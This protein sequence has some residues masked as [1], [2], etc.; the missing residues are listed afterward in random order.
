MAGNNLKIPLIGVLIAIYLVCGAP[1]FLHSDNAYISLIHHFFHANV[2]H[3]AVN[4]F[5]LWFL[6]RKNMSYGIV[7]LI[8]AFL[9]STASWFCTTSDAIGIS[10]F[11]FAIVGLRTPPLKDSWWRHSSVITFLIVTALMSLLPQVSAVTHIVS[12]VLGCLVAGLRRLIKKV[13]SDFSRAT[14]C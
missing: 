14:Y 9:I 10:N 1:M 8:L 11:I 2:F 4:C 12:F 3:L 7:T 6:F 5:S 13:G